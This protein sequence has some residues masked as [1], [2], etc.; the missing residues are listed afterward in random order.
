[1]NPPPDVRP[2]GA[3][4]IARSIITDE[5]LRQHRAMQTE[6]YSNGHTE[7]GTSGMTGLEAA[8]LQEEN[9]AVLVNSSFF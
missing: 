1:M 9:T 2:G 6:R 4:H 8:L 3:C 5:L 7:Y